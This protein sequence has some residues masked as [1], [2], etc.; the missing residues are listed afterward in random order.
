M[1]LM[2]MMLGATVGGLL[3]G[4]ASARAGMYSTATDEGDT[5]TSGVGLVS[6]ITSSGFVGTIGSITLNLVITGGSTGHCT[7]I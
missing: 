2:K 6:T 4:D 5:I 3:L 1:K 7:A